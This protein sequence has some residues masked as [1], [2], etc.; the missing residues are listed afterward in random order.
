VPDDKGNISMVLS[1]GA[2]LVSGINAGI[3]SATPDGTN[4]GHLQVRLTRIGSTTPDNFSLS[5][6]LG[7]QLRGV[8]D[9]R[10]NGMRQALDALD[11]MA[12]DF[13]TA[14][15]TQH[16][17]GFDLNGAAGQALFTLPVTAP[18]A[19]RSISVN[20][21]IVGNPS[22]LAASSTA[23]T[24]PG[25]AGN[26]L[27]LLNTERQALSTGADA[28]GALS[29]IVANYG[30]ATRTARALSDQ[31]ESIANH[32]SALRESTSGVSIDEEI[33]EMTKAQRAFE[34]VTK[35]ITVTD[36]LLGV[37]MDLK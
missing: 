27:A 11:T 37:L 7:G 14:L 32:L 9:A 28:S 31:D 10:D 20:A 15:N 33:I 18:G 19:A 24:V 30:F 13:G 5:G 21:A 4:N 36:G 34:A 22:L 23:T 29:A 1:N 8:L 16:Q 26:I 17:A 12:F 6:M 3:L 2:A 25:D 35:V